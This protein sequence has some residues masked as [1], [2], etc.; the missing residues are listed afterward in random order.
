MSKEQ[1]FNVSNTENEERNPWITETKLDSRRPNILVPLR[2]YFK[3]RT[4][5]KLVQEILYPLILIVLICVTGRLN[6]KMEKLENEITETKNVLKEIDFYSEYNLNHLNS[7][8]RLNCEKLGNKTRKSG[9][10]LID[11]DGRNEGLGP[12]KVYCDFNSNMT[13]LKPLKNET[14]SVGIKKETFEYEA[15]LDQIKLLIA[16]SGS[17]YQTIK[18]QYS[19][20]YYGSG[21]WLDYKGQKHQITRGKVSH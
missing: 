11:L 6:A 10:F 8:T 9:Y 14:K 19:G 5:S 18:I 2:N 12:M 13:R 20:N 15:S 3:T 1:E 16:N 17:C 4:R 7:V 21:F